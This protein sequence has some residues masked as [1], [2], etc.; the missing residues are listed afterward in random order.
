MIKINLLPYQKA[1]KV[2]RKQA[3]EAQILLAILV[4]VGLT[5][6]LGFFW[7][8]LNDSIDNQRTTR[9]QVKVQLEDLKKKVK[10]VEDLEE[11]KK[12]V[13]EK[14]A[15]IAQLKKNQQGPVRVLDELSSHLPSRVWLV[16]LSQTSNAFDLDGRAVTNFEIVD[17]FN[18][19][20]T[21]PFI[22]DLELV[23]SRQGAEGG[24][25]IYQ[26]KMKFKLKT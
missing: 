5:A 24:L 3:F 16:S 7:L 6:G 9:D 12:L 13:E 2:K 19:L 25:T 14:I 26:F 18:K 15:I 20:K 10:E 8:A 1:S 22:S 4:F 23:E 21:S 11:R 17:Y